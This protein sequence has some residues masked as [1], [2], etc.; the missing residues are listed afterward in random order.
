MG[1]PPRQRQLL[2]WVVWLA[3]VLVSAALGAHSSFEQFA[4][5]SAAALSWEFG[6]SLLSDG[7]QVPELMRNSTLCP[8]LTV[9]SGLSSSCD[10]AGIAPEGAYSI[11]MAEGSVFGTPSVRLLHGM[12]ES[13]GPLGAADGMTPGLLAHNLALNESYVAALWWKGP[14]ARTKAITA[15]AIGS[16]L[17]QVEEPDNVGGEVVQAV[18]GVTGSSPTAFQTGSLFNITCIAHDPQCVPYGQLAIQTTLGGVRMSQPWDDA[19]YLDHWHFVVIAFD[20]DSWSFRLW[21]DGIGMPQ[22]C[23]AM[24]FFQLN[25]TE[26]T[27]ESGLPSI[28][29]VGCNSSRIRSTV[30]GPP[31][32]QTIKPFINV[33]ATMLNVGYG[34]DYCLGDWQ[35]PTSNSGGSVSTLSIHLT[36]RPLTLASWLSLP[37]GSPT[38]ATL[39]M[40]SIAGGT[41]S[42]AHSSSSSN[43]GGRV[44][45]AASCSD[46]RHVPMIPLQ[47]LCS[48][49]LLDS[50]GQA[51]LCE[52]GLPSLA[53]GER[54]GVYPSVGLL[55]GQTSRFSPIGWTSFLG[56][57]APKT[58]QT[59]LA[60]RNESSAILAGW[61]ASMPWQR[62][63]SDL[64][65]STTP[66]TEQDGSSILRCTSLPEGLTQPWRGWDH[67]IIQICLGGESVL[68]D[69]QDA[70]EFLVTDS[71]AASLLAS[72]LRIGMVSLWNSTTDR[73][74][75]GSAGFVTADVGVQI[76]NSLFGLDLTEEELCWNPVREAYQSK[77][78]AVSNISSCVCSYAIVR[79]NV[80]PSQFAMDAPMNVQSS[81]A[82]LAALLAG[83]LRFSPTITTPLT[84]LTSVSPQS[85]FVAP[86]PRCLTSSAAASLFVDPSVPLSVT[87]WAQNLLG[88]ALPNEPTVS[89]E[90]C[91]KF[92]AWDLFS[93]TVTPPVLLLAYC[94]VQVGFCSGDVV[95]TSEALDLVVRGIC[96]SLGGAV[97]CGGGC[98]VRYPDGIKA[99][100]AIQLDD[101]AAGGSVMRS[102][103]PPR[104]VEI[105]RVVRSNLR[106]SHF[107]SSSESIESVRGEESTH[108]EAPLREGLCHR[109]QALPVLHRDRIVGFVSLVTALQCG[110]A[111]ASLAMVNVVNLWPW[112]VILVGVLGGVATRLLVVT[113]GFCF[114]RRAWLQEHRV[115]RLSTPFPLRGSVC[116]RC[117]SLTITSVL[118]LVPLGSDLENEELLMGAG[119]EEYKG[120]ALDRIARWYQ[121]SNLDSAMMSVLD[122][123]SLRRLIPASA[124]PRS[125]I[126]VR[127]LLG[128]IE[129]LVGVPFLVV[130]LGGIL[131]AMLQANPPACASLGAVSAAS[132]LLGC[133]GSP[134]C[135]RFGCL[136]LGEALSV[137]GLP[138]LFALVLTIVALTSRV[139]D[140][141]HA[142]TVASSGSSNGSCCSNVWM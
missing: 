89:W 38:T 47:E 22:T 54:M 68:D 13:P 96:T 115:M 72:L 53:I 124:N 20:R 49:E 29:T 99:T 26:L 139:R 3:C 70:A 131:A 66:L 56:R 118:V 50:I 114:A 63:L 121:A 128:W 17:S 32:C 135:A 34:W 65:N 55:A 45:C 78:S 59:S 33:S 25:A 6:R 2:L 16:H 7:F 87:Q 40:P 24:D 1:P 91:S 92:F 107:S 73:L 11:A 100:R 105:S 112:Y 126:V 93:L 142:W 60:P 36:D 88:A 136:L 119:A 44:I 37:L 8:N 27:P 80:A 129:S 120:Q 23:D 5:E 117:G 134:L 57:M 116:A 127:V 79:S 132:S 111:I 141:F 61:A 86:L 140:V 58:F 39:A 83:A 94:L 122:F 18:I 71:T 130:C 123:R 67:Q 103:E 84:R 102:I 51:E 15:F 101:S 41:V 106:R 14:Q 28:L 90:S 77:F 133:Q 138:L 113:C 97:C 95:P 30:L 62:V 76:T 137:L 35:C 82:Y 104:Q 46:P 21:V 81:S 52:G 12:F 74:W 69:R 48:H 43:D 125:A 64:P 75:L 10:L 108:V 85:I 31:F 19:V 98:V 9:P 4:A 109:I 110:I 42:C